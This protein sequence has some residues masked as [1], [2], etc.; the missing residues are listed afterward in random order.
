[1]LIEVFLEREGCF[2][3][4]NGICPECYKPPSTGKEAHR[5]FV[6]VN[7]ICNKHNKKY[8]GPNVPC[9]SVLTNTTLHIYYYTCSSHVAL[10]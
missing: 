4:L 6:G 3:L 2:P 9:V 5:T 7:N 1:M 8:R 10:E